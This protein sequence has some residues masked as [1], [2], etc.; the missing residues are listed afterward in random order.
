MRTRGTAIVLHN[1]H[2]LLVRDAGKQA[3]SLPSGGVNRNQ[4]ALASAVRALMEELSMA[5]HKAER[6][7]KCDCEI[8]FILHQVSLIETKDPP[9]L[10]SN[11]LEEYIW[12][13]LKKPI[14]R[15]P[16]VDAI[17]EAYT[18]RTLKNVVPTA[19]LPKKRGAPT[20]AD[21][22]GRNPNEQSNHYEHKIEGDWLGAPKKG[23]HSTTGTSSDEALENP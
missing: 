15:Y 1:N 13:D 8:C 12:W 7:F 5:A 9:H 21:I 10:N 17:L 23:Q 6:I 3:Y 18:G 2:V 11:K 14:P 20:I 16:H 19:P 22:I 4:P